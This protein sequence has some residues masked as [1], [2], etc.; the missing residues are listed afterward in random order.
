MSP[1]SIALTPGAGVS[2]SRE[3]SIDSTAASI[4]GSAAPGSLISAKSGM[5]KKKKRGKRTT[6]SGTAD[7]DVEYVE[8]MPEEK[9]DEEAEIAAAAQLATLEGGQMSEAQKKQEKKH[10]Q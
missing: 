1:D 6:R 8:D 5:S 4:R 3:M 2:F 10:I 7:G 9:D